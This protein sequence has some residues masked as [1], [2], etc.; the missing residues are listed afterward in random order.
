MP[1]NIYQSDSTNLLR[2]PQ[3]FYKEKVI[4]EIFHRFPVSFSHQLFPKNMKAN[5][6]DC[7]A[8]KKTL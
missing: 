3:Q 2:T 5:E 8:C 1:V 4:L 7:A 6:G